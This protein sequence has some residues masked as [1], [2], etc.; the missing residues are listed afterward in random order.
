MAIIYMYENRVQQYILDII[1]NV[2]WTM[3]IWCTEACIL[4]NGDKRIE[5]IEM[6]FIRPLSGDRAVALWGK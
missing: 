5:R 3:V 1:Q 2:A 6:N 4:G